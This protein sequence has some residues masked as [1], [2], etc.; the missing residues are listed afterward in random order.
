MAL[1]KSRHVFDQLDDL[2]EKERSA[3]LN[4]DFE[5]L[6]RL[7]DKKERIMAQI[8]QQTEPS[9]RLQSLQRKADRNQRLLIAAGNG[10]RTVSDFLKRL[11]KPSDPLRTTIRQGRY[12]HMRQA[13]HRPGVGRDQLSF[14]Q[15]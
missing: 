9:Q 8:L 14:F 5:T 4:G 7:M 13:R 6:R 12:I 1:F 2:L 11:E 3:V 15:M 10:I